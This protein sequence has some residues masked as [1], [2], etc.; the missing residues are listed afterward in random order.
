MSTAHIPFSF[1]GRYFPSME[2]AQ[3]FL[4]AQGEEYDSDSLCD[5]TTTTL[6][7]QYVREGVYILGFPLQPGQSDEVAKALWSG[8]L[9]TDNVG[10]KSYFEILT[11]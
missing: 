9:D 1:Y 8:R 11:Y 7:L 6:G 5:E 3:A 4:D 10:A 2:S